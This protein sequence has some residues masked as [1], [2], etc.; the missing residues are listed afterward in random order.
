[1]IP[2]VE[3]RTARQVERVAPRGLW[4]PGTALSGALFMAAVAGLTLG[5]LAATGTSIADGRWF[6]VVQAHA[7][8]QLWA[9]LAISI[10]ALMFEFVVRLNGRPALGLVPRVAALGLLGGGAMLAATAGTAASL[11]T[12]LLVAGWACLVAGSALTARLVASVPMARHLRDDLHPL[13]FRTGVA[14]L[15]VSAVLGAWGS[16]RVSAG[17]IPPPVF[18]AM[19][20]VFLRGFALHVTVGVG[21]RAFPGHLGLAPVPVRQQVV[22]YA[23][24]NASIF[25]LSVDASAADLLAGVAAVHASY[26]FGVHRL[27]R[28][29]GVP[30][31]RHGLLVLVTW[32]GLVAWGV[33]LTGASVLAVAGLEPAPF[34][35]HGAVRHVLMA[36]FIGP[37]IVAMMHIVLERFGTG[38]LLGRAWLHAAFVFLIVAW[39]LRVAPPM[40]DPS[41]SAI[42]QGAMGVAGVLMMIGLLLAGGVAARN[43]LEARH[44]ERALRRRDAR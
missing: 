19:V 4:L 26:A 2:F 37:L 32:I 31:E 40:L 13:F 8:I 44:L 28:H 23:L 42:T 39:P 38:R 9:W 35:A 15:L 10:A 18:D 24:L 20:E 12:A 27:L 29:P 21:L 17:A 22:L 14:W 36:G 11:P 16:L 3:V 30:G 7:T 43:A 34:L 1:M 5:I 41:A 33:F 25:L 6:P